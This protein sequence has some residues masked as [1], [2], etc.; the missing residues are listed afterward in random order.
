MTTLLAQTHTPAPD[1]LATWISVFMY[2]GG[3]L[4]TILGGALA[5]KKLREP[6]A[7]VAPQPFL[8]KE[9]PGV[10]SQVEIDQV[11][12]RIA[13]E[14]R[15]VEEK[16]AELKAEDTRLREKLDEEISTLQDRIDAVPERT[17]NLL[18]STKGLI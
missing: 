15:E 3:F 13:R 16:I 5:L 6:A 4:C 8:V 1:V 7:P 9:H 17:I 14:R 11:H 2:L 10:V 18:K 12:G